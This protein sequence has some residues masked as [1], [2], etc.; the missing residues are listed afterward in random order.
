MATLSAMVGTVLHVTDS[1]QFCQA[2]S[3]RLVIM[4]MPT[5]VE[6]AFTSMRGVPA[7]ISSAFKADFLSGIAF[8]K[9]FG[10]FP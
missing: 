1:S 10:S 8:P 5:I 9:L 4:S 3:S 2:S 6:R 7:D